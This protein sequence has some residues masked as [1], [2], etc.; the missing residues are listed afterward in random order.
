[1]YCCLR[2]HAIVFLPH[3]ASKHCANRLAKWPRN[4]AAR[5]SVAGVLLAKELRPS[6]HKG[7]CRYT[8]VPRRFLPLA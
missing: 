8:S 1:M 4:T 2:A 3:A 5:P 7:F 6:L